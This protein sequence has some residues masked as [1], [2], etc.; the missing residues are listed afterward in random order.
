MS[1]IPHGGDSDEK[2]LPKPQLTSYEKSGSE[3]ELFKDECVIL[4]VCNAPFSGSERSEDRI[5]GKLRIQG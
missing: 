5:I 1:T 3:A 4:I 2:G